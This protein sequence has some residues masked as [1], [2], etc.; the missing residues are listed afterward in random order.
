MFKKKRENTLEKPLSQSSIKH[1]YFEIHGGKKTIISEDKVGIIYL[2]KAVFKNQDRVLISIKQFHIPL[3]KDVAKEY[4]SA[5]STLKDLKAKKDAKFSSKPKNVFLRLNILKTQTERNIQ[6]EWVFVSHYH[7][8][9]N[10]KY[11]ERLE[12]INVDFDSK[13]KELVWVFVKFLENRIYPTNQ[14][15]LEFLNIDTKKTINLDKI[16]KE[17]EDLKKTSVQTDLLI[18]KLR[19][20]ASQIC[21]KDKK[22]I[23]DKTLYDL[24]SLAIDYSSSKKI[25]LKL[26]S[27]KKTIRF[28]KI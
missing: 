17:K 4:R 5:I 1:V 8:K 10:F 7:D 12:K 19:W 14:L 16:V 2:G 11:D 9:S 25:K 24:C 13:E 6:G 26:S 18:T 27:F 15:V 22:Q 23:C 3:E 28:D 21:K 20:L